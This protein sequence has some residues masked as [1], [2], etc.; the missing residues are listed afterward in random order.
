M[1]AVISMDNLTKSYGEVR[2]LNGLS[3]EIP[4]GGVYGILGPNGAGKSTLFRVLLGLIEPTSGRAEVMGYPIGHAPTLRQI[5]SMI[6][7]PRYPAYMS[8]RDCLVWLALAHGQSRD[9]DFDYWLER[10]GLAEAAHR[11]V[12]GYS[13]G[14]MQRLGIAAALMTR[15][16]LVILDEPTSGMDPP[17]ILE[18]RSLI[19]GLTENDGVTVILASHQLLEVQRICD[20]V[21][22]FNRGRLAA[23]G[24]VAELSQSGQHLRLT[25]TPLAKIKEIVGDAGEIVGDAILVNIRREDTA[26]LIRHL[27]MEDVDVMEAQWVGADLE[28]IFIAQTRNTHAPQEADHAV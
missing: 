24:S 19:K 13:V 7:N 14:M 3:L 20:R 9:I 27:V 10:V 25:A 17:G 21:A 18:I 2:A 26:G 8:A 16:D 28:A 22:I 5:G 1:N 11:K 4:K 23:E 6:E 12:N 15:P